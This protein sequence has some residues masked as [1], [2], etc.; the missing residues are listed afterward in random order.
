M[1]T[2]WHFANPLQLVDV[3]EGLIYL[4]SEGFVH[5]DLKGVRACS[6]SSRPRIYFHTLGQRAR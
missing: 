3:C 1:F 6:S 4:H 2:V 5:G